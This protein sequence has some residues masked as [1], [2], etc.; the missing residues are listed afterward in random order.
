M[1]K[2]AG[3][4]FILLS[5][6]CMVFLFAGKSFGLS[7]SLLPF[8]DKQIGNP[9]NKK[10]IDDSVQAAV[11]RETTEVPT[12]EATG[13]ASFDPEKASFVNSEGKRIIREPDDYLVL[14]NKSYNL[15]SDWE[16][17]D[18]VVPNITFAFSGDAPR[19][20]MRE[21]AARALEGLF[22]KAREDNIKIAATSGY[23]SYETQ[24][25][26][27][28]TNA[29]KYGEKQ[30]NMTS[31]Y[32]GQSE[33]QTGLAMDITCAGVNFDLVEA[34]GETAE[35]RWLAK[36]AA[37]FGFIIRYPEDKV[38]ITKYNYEPWHVRYVGQATAR[39]ISEEGITLEEYFNAVD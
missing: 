17:K 13:R 8:V 15:P 3:K 12:A 28:Q 33:H 11:P 6:L 14:V 19:K 39:A 34:F 31:A 7:Y 4:F 26:I 16:P 24:K 5:A 1:L 30:A 2:K 38:N 25:R 9:P 23:R 21:E 36:N 29:Q 27:F 10:I 35:G 32:P 20:Y 22:N 37:E 18:L